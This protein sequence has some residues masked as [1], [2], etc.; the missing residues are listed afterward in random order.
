MRVVTV[1][2]SREHLDRYLASGE[3]P[4]ARRL[5]EDAGGEP[6]AEILE[7]VMDS[8]TAWWP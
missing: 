1:W 5:L 8:N 2:R 7:P 6:I 3:K 4:F